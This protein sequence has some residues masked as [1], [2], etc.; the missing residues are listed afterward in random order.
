[1]IREFLDSCGI[2]E[3]QQCAIICIT[4]RYGTRNM[5]SR[6]SNGSSLFNDRIA[7]ILGRTYCPIK[8]MSGAPSRSAR[9]A[10]MRV[11]ALKSPRA[12]STD[13]FFSWKHAALS[14]RSKITR[15]YAE[16]EPSVQRCRR[17]VCA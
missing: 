10:R 16:R 13:P 12:L 5:H 2:L 1:M 3:T 6:I 4:L 11:I 15:N 8:L 9:N 17:I 14:R 7:Y